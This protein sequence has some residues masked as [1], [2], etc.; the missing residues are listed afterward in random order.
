MSALLKTVPSY[1]K[2]S[3]NIKKPSGGMAPVM[4]DLTFGL[5]SIWPENVI[6]RVYDCLVTFWLSPECPEI[7]KWKFICPIPKRSD[8]IGRKT[9]LMIKVTVMYQGVTT[10]DCT[11]CYPLPRPMA[12]EENQLTSHQRPP[13]PP[14][15]I[16]GCEGVQT[17]LK[18]SRLVLLSSFPCHLAQQKSL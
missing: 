18:S 10:I 7:L 12:S 9:K 14:T 1:E 16:L 13:H 17:F 11:T 5:M 15:P 8:D 2:F 6:K 4:S 3:R